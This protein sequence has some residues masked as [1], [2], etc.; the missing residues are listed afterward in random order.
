[1]ATKTKN[2]VKEDCVAVQNIKEL[3]KQIAAV[4]FPTGTPNAVQERLTNLVKLIVT[5]AD[6]IQKSM[7]NSKAR[8]ERIAKTKARLYKKIADAQAALKKLEG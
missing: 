4:K 3:A 2:V 1:M 7:G 6:S 5:K 8:I